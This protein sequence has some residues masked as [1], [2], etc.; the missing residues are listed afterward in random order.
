M[1]I[2]HL[3]NVEFESKWQKYKG[4]IVLP[5]DIT[6]MTLVHTRYAQIKERQSRK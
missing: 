2:C 1:K 3:K 5:G 4:R 6:K